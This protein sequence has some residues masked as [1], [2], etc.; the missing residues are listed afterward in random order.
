[1][2]FYKKNG[3]MGTGVR[4]RTVGRS[5]AEIV[6]NIPSLWLFGVWLVGVGEVKFAATFPPP[7]LDHLAP[8]P[9]NGYWPDYVATSVFAR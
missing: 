6:E 3:Q 8:V 1:M 4:L 5:R 9:G 2:Q 7:V